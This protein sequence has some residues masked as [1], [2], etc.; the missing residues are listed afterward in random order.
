M[1]KVMEYSGPD[2]IRRTDEEEDEDAFE[3]RRAARLRRMEQ[4][5]K[6]RRK[7]MIRRRIIFAAVVLL[8]AGI[9]T[10]S[11]KAIR[12]AKDANPVM[13][14][15]LEENATDIPIIRVDA[16]GNPIDPPGTEEAGQEELTAAAPATGVL[17]AQRS[18]SLRAIPEEV[19]S[20]YVCFVDLA[21]NEVIA[22]R[23]MNS[24]MVPASMTKVLTLLVAAEHLDESDLA[25][26]VTITIDITDY[27]YKNDCSVV[28]FDKD[29]TVPVK[30]LLYGTILPSGADAALALANYVAGDQE[31]FV[32]LMNQKLAQLGISDS[33]HFTNCIGTYDDAHYCRPY[34]M[35]VIMKAAMDN[36]LCREV[37]TTRVYTTA[38]TAQHPEGLTIS[39]WFL[40]R[41]EDKDC[42]GTVMGGKTGYVVQSGNCAVSF[43]ADGE[44]R[45]Y[46]CVTGGSTSSWRCIYDHVAL[47]KAY[48]SGAKESAPAD[49][50]LDTEAETAAE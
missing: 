20:S 13:A 26:D 30:D 35:A 7:A 47:Y 31:H 37:L 43:G 42:G 8:F 46:I 24:R 15:D 32:E 14:E 18:A 1:K 16:D 3:A 45:E 39:N 40:R 5:R 10:L 4:R 41:I 48:T 36:P 33:A 6:A 19:V 25:N 28:G 38:A 9:L 21:N 12:E 49:A 50:V 17:N 34:D 2:V 11:V 27:T 29:E 22:D 23:E 44:G